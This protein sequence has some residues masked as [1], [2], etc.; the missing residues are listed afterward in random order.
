MLG[1]KIKVNRIFQSVMAGAEES[2]QMSINEETS[3]RNIRPPSFNVDKFAD[4]TEHS[5]R[6]ELNSKGIG[7]SLVK[8]SGPLNR[9][10]LGFLN[11]RNWSSSK[12]LN[13]DGDTKVST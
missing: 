12:G 3:I 1:T 11:Q 7:E 13:I 5:V 8:E 2:S 9:N 6:V 10:D 4:K